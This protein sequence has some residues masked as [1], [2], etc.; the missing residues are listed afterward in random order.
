MPAN[1][2]A[3]YQYEGS[4]LTET[5]IVRT[6][7]ATVPTDDEQPESRLIV[8]TA[9]AQWLR[10]FKGE[11]LAIWNP[12]AGAAVTVSVYGAAV[13]SATVVNSDEIWLE[14]EYLNSGSAQGAIVTTTKAD[15]LA[16]GSPVASDSSVWLAADGTTTF[17]V[18]D[19]YISSG[20]ALSNGNKT[21]TH[22]GTANNQGVRSATFVSTGKFY[23]EILCNAGGITPDV[24]IISNSASGIGAGGEGFYTGVGVTN[25]FISNNLGTVG[26]NL[27]SAPTGTIFCFAIN[28]T[29]NLGCRF[30]K[31]A[32]PG[33]PT[34]PP[35]RQRALR[36]LQ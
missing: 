17:P 7:G 8:T 33:M 9:G 4:E 16:T 29:D 31:T 1:T 20:V 21:A 12:T 23:F 25:S 32:A 6:G 36:A 30:A 35:I 15:L 14:V 24:G 18:L 22:T 11:P 19:G 27:G 28:L 2:S 10:P 13:G 26:I 3:R 5:L 34:G